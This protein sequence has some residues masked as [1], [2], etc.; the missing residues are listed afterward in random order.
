VDNGWRAGW[1]L[2]E[3]RPDFDP[4]RGDRRFQ[5]ILEFIRADMA[6]QLA[7]VRAME[8]SGE[9]PPMQPPSEL[10]AGPSEAHR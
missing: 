4:I 6:R 1:W 3:S 8:A 7:N 10:E 5:A 9:I 2:I